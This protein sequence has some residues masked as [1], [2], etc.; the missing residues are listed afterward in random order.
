MEQLKSRVSLEVWRR[1]LSQIN[2]AAT[3]RT[4]FQF[5]GGEETLEFIEFEEGGRELVERFGIQ[6][7]VLEEIAGKN[8][9]SLRKLMKQLGVEG[10]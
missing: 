1:G 7:E 4:T 3:D 9:E 8:E 2:E 10:E 6:D 5:G